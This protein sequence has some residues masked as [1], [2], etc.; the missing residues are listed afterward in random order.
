[1]EPN[2]GWLLVKKA[3]LDKE[4]E[5]E[6]RR[7]ELEAIAHDQMAACRIFAAE[8]TTER[9]QLKRLEASIMDQLYNAPKPFCDIPD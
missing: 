9:R 2:D 4:A 6:C 5:Y 3:A 7:K 8:L 1:M